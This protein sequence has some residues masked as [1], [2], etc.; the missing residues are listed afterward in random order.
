MSAS[1][2]FILGSKSWS[3]GPN[4]DVGIEN[5]DFGVR[6]LHLGFKSLTV[7][8]SGTLTALVKAVCSLVNLTRIK[9][10]GQCSAKDSSSSSPGMLGRSQSRGG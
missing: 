2:N 9:Y 7:D 5:I 6:N 4:L 10:T 8:P 1:G 3:W